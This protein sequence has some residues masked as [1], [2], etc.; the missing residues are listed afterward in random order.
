MGKKGRPLEKDRDLQDNIRAKL[1]LQKK[2]G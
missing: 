1:P 2:I